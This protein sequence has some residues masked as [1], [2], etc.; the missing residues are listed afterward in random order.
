MFILF[1]SGLAAQ[2]SEINHLYNSC[3]GEKDVISLYIPGFLCRLGAALGDMD[4]AERELLYSIK[5]I[6]LLVS[7]NKELN[8]HINFVKEINCKKHG[9]GYV[10]L[11][12]VH[13]SGEDVLI[14]GKERN[15]YVS[16]LLIVIGGNDN[17]LIY[18]KGRMNKDLLDALYDVTGIEECLYMKEI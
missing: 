8:E 17:V 11:I 1:V 16:E 4:D 12:E 15:G 7:E 3:R 2:S 18:I 5:S 13:D 6:R 14:L 10:S 9:S